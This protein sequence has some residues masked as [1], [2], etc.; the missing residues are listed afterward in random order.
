MG[1]LRG[2]KHADM[3][4]EKLKLKGWLSSHLFQEQ[5]PAHYAEIIHGL[6]LPEYM[7]PKSGVLN[8]AT[9]LPQEIPKPDLGP[10]VYISYGS[11]EE[12][13]Q[14]DSVTK[15]C[16][17]LCD[18]VCLVLFLFIYSLVKYSS[19]SKFNLCTLSLSS[20]C[21]FFLCI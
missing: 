21:N 3:C 10:S 18:V 20:F 15:L 4:N 12:L 14:G 17:D 16:Y 7:D 9:K 19:L 5:F 2:P 11:G 13:A 1:S 8:I 6:P